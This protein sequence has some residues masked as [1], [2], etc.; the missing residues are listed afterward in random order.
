MLATGYVADC[1]LDDTRPI[2]AKSK[3]LNIRLVADARL[4]DDSNIEV[5]PVDD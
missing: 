2:L 3:E 4:S 1:Q 5:S